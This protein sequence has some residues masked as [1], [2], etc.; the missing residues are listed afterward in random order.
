MNPLF[1][2]RV[3]PL[4]T[5]RRPNLLLICSDHNFSQSFHYHLPSCG[6]PYI[7]CHQCKELCLQVGYY[8]IRFSLRKIYVFTQYGKFISILHN[9][10]Q[11][12]F[13]LKLKMF[14]LYLCQ[15][16]RSQLCC[17]LFQVVVKQMASITATL[18]ALL[19]VV[20]GGCKA[21]AFYNSDSH[22]FVVCCF[23]WL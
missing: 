4:Y 11:G 7:T 19:Y 21:D 20:S 9:L 12:H 6:A 2:L 15:Q 8:H 5:H 13:D 1:S 22:S 16:R 14:L 18:T 23:R 10:K 3:H 17:L